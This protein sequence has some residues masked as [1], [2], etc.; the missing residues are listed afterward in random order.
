MSVVN[1]EL[2]SVGLRAESKNPALLLSQQDFSALEKVF[3]PHWVWPGNEWYLDN[4]SD[5]TWAHG[6]ALCAITGI[7]LVRSIPDE[8][9]VFG[10][11]GHRKEAFR[12]SNSEFDRLGCLVNRN[13]VSL[14]GIW[15][16]DPVILV[17]CCP[18]E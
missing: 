9:S 3:G 2:A 10:F 15:S 5:A 17:L 16:F 1:L 12:L 4:G 13:Q 14:Y 8:F 6:L 18:A 7:P 11:G